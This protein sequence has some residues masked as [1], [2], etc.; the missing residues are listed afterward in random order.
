MVAN[1]I[2]VII[3]SET[4]TCA[5]HTGPMLPHHDVDLTI[6]QIIRL[7]RVLQHNADLLHSVCNIHCPHDGIIFQ[8]FLDV[9][10]CML[11]GNSKT[12]TR[13]WK[14]ILSNEEAWRAQIAALLFHD[15]YRAGAAGSISVNGGGKQMATYDVAKVKCLHDKHVF[16][17]NPRKAITSWS[18]SEGRWI[19]ALKTLRLVLFMSKLVSLQIAVKVSVSNRTSEGARELTAQ[20]A[21]AI[22]NAVRQV[23][24]FHFP[25]DIESV[26]LDAKARKACCNCE[27]YTVPL[28]GLASIMFVKFDQVTGAPAYTSRFE[29]CIDDGHDFYFQDANRKYGM[30]ESWSFHS[31]TIIIYC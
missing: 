21:T 4:G 7:P 30:K 29:C 25:K 28:D 16:I 19:S 8:A 22:I 13:S 6:G 20:Y 11:P 15:Q 24:L 10:F 31:L 9:I 14:E 1:T 12:E 3:L 2:Q 17:A 23:S 26:Q 5:A 27:I 18:R